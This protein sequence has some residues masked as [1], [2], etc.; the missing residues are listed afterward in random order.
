M[1]NAGVE[2]AT[3]RF[4]TKALPVELISLCRL[5][6]CGR[7]LEVAVGIEPTMTGFADQLLTTWIRYRESGASDGIRTR[8][9]RLGK[10]VLN[11]MSFTRMEPVTPQSNGACTPATG[12]TGTS[13][14]DLEGI[15]PSTSA[16]RTPRSLN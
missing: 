13:L 14:V 11:L 15:K 6:T 3:V 2:P 16:L 10:P 12:G 9:P 8:Y 7:L 5:Q 4:K 1:E